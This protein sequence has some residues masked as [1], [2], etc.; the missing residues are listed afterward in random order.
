[1]E[2]IPIQLGSYIAHLR[3]IA[4]GGRPAVI[5]IHGLGVSGTYFI[6]FA[7][8][9]ARQYDVYIIDLPGYG[10]TPKPQRALTISELSEL[11]ASFIQTQNI[12]QVIAIGQSMGCQI[13]AH[14]SA[15]H[16]SLF[17][18][19]ILLAPTV[20]DKERSVSMQA[21]RLIED[22]FHEPLKVT[23]I[24]LRDY[25]RMG[26][27][28]YLAT[29][30]NMVNDHIEDT[31]KRGKLP[32]GII[33]GKRDKI[34]PHDWTILLTHLPA[35]RLIAEVADAPHLLHYKKPKEVAELCRRFIED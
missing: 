25:L 16:P 29:S 14:A 32:I 27:T 18:K 30:Q 34:V 13:I 8:E 2:R 7:K 22:T 19:I 4:T 1:M 23:C 26:V 31:L 12:T 9:L 15:A 24:V 28:R 35:V 6:P 11:V 21:L 3:T 17:K 10:K 33:R 5:L 20:N